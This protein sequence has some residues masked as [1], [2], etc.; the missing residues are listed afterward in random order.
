MGVIT[1]MKT[2]IHPACVAFGLTVL[3]S[4][5]FADGVVIPS[6]FEE[7]SAAAGIPASVVYSIGLIETGRDIEGVGRRPYPWVLGLP[8]RNGA[9]WFDT[10]DETV[11]RLEELIA[12]GEQN[13]DVGLMQ[14]NWRWHKERFDGPAEAV[15]PYR[16]VAVATE[17][18]KE[19]WLE[20][21]DLWRA[22]GLYHSR[23]PDLAESYR[24]RYGRWFI[25][26]ILKLDG[27][28]SLVPQS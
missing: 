6:A 28:D 8:G 1:I 21:N 10:Q 22:I 25:Q 12:Q 26:T 19:H 9:E 3:A 11:A 5:T 16:N 17:I 20:T 13:I 2:T 24:D 14:L 7:A 15:D 27:N 23:T 18:L 4:Q